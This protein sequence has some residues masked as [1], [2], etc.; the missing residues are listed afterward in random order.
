[1][2][3]FWLAWQI[4]FEHSIDPADGVEQV[5]TM[6]IDRFSGK[7]VIQPKESALEEAKKY[8]AGL[9]ML[10]D[11]SEDRVGRVGAAICWR[12]KSLDSWKEK[13]FFLGKNKE[14]IDAELWAISE[15]L[16]IAVKKPNNTTNAPVTI[17]CDSQEALRA[18]EHPPSHKR[19][20]F[21]RG[22][23]YEK[24]KKLSGGV[25]LRMFV[26]IWYKQDLEN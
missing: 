7:I 14:I 9:V 17:F 2:V 8:R 13:S 5:E 22:S 16:D 1:M 25:H 24:T 4:S 19:N 12:E 6:E 3:L 11:G 10:T 23:I 20:R 21:L 26:K 18:I 15:A